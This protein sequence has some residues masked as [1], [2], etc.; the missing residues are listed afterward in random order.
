MLRKILSPDTCARCRLC[1]QFDASD[2]WELPVLPGETVSAVQKLRPDTAFT[3]VDEEY[4][5]ASPALSGEE[6]FACP[7]LTDCGCGLTPEDKPF[8]C[9]IWPFRLMKGEDGSCV[10]AVSELCEGIKHLSDDALRKFLMDEGLGEMCFAYAEEHPAHVK[11]FMKGYR[12][13]L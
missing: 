4:T 10:V 2:I 5:F 6:L 1:C 12:I 13:I 9:K 7:V 3:S 8:D 11:P